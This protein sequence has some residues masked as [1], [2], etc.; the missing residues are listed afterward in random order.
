MSRENGG[1]IS[2]S[3]LGTLTDGVFAIVMTLLVL[4]ITVPQISQPDVETELINTLFDLWPA[5]FSY[6]TSFIILGFFWIGHD[7]M[8]HYIKRVNRI[9]IWITIFYLMFVAL[10]PFTTGLIEE[11]GDQQIAVMIYGLVITMV[12]F[13]VYV[14]WRYATKDF[15]LVDKDLDP[16]FITRMSRRNILV[17]V[18]FLTAIALSFVNIYIALLIY[19]ALPFFYIKPLQKDKS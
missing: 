10:I 1:T 19:I 15:H 17:P 14:Q 6:A 3:R 12:G 2:K 8:F 4:E 9:F 5:I 11:Y 13:L 16:G 7:N 18:I